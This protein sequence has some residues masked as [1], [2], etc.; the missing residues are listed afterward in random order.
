MVDK[1]SNDWRNG[2][3]SDVVFI[4]VKYFI[5]LKCYY[6]FLSI[7]CWNMGIMVLDEFSFF[8]Y[9]FVNNLLEILFFNEVIN[10]CKLIYISRKFVKI[11][12]VLELFW[13]VVICLWLNLKMI[14]YNGWLIIYCNIIKF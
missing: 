11:L 6:G 14:F 13:L 10:D 5:G 9:G 12:F 3:L 2:S 7:F 1:E 4:L 8:N